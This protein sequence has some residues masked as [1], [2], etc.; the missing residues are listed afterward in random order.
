VTDS[1]L[2][3]QYHEDRSQPMAISN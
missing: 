3:I 2:I 1:L